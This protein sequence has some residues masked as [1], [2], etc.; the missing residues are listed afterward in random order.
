MQHSPPVKKERET[1]GNTNPTDTGSN[2]Q[3]KT[4]A[5]IL[6]RT[7][8]ISFE[9]LTCGFLKIHSII[10]NVLTKGSGDTRPPSSVVFVVLPFVITVVNGFCC[11]LCKLRGPLNVRGLGHDGNSGTGAGFALGKQCLTGSL[12]P[13]KSHEMH[14]SLGGGSHLSQGCARHGAVRSTEAMGR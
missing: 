8:P 13:V 7:K 4:I 9:P 12:C 3:R 1:R 6:K 11:F 10:F 14:G 5:F 2:F